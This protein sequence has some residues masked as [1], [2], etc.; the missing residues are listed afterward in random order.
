MTGILGVP[1]S[2]H[3]LSPLSCYFP[4]NNMADA[5]GWGLHRKTS[6]SQEIWI[7]WQSKLALNLP[8]SGKQTREFPFAT[9]HEAR[10]SQHIILEASVRWMVSI[11]PAKLSHLR[12]LHPESRKLQQ[13]SLPALELGHCSLKYTA[14]GQP[15]WLHPAIKGTSCSTEP[16]EGIFLFQRRI[17]PTN[18]KQYKELLFSFHFLAV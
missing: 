17:R 7:L 5:L 13:P 14:P 10:L 11:F 3:A 12:F 6:I 16:C 4:H 15:G 1:G 18:H 9:S 8:M 2:S